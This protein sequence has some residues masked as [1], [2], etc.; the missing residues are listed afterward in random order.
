MSDAPPALELDGVHSYYGESHVLRG[1]DLAVEQGENVALVGRNGVGKTTTL[2]SILGLTPPR[3]GS[4]RLHGE[5]ITGTE[6]HEIA[7]RG[8]GWVPEGRR[9]FSH[10]SVEENL[11]AATRPDADV[12][13]RVEEALDAFP[14][15]RDHRTRDAGDLSGGQQQMVAIARALVGDNDLLLVDEPSEGLA[16]LIVEEVVDAL[17]SL[18]EDVTLLLV[19]Q[20]FP[21][22]MDLTDRFYLLDHGTVVESGDSDAVSQD[23]ETIRRYLSA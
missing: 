3:E 16:P 2:R 21:M 5:D 6:T 12:A 14:E 13:A 7:R 15:L 8:V 20:N 10:L 19:E 4:V 18:A 23:D 1:V 17:S 11:R 22:A 9:M